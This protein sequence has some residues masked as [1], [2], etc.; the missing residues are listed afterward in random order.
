MFLACPIGLGNRLPCSVCGGGIPA[1]NRTHR[2]RI[3][4]ER[5]DELWGTDASRFWTKLESWCWFFAAVDHCASDVVGWHV[6]KKGDRWAAL[7]ML[8]PTVTNR[9]LPDCICTVIT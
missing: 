6:A 1:E 5:P 7:A 4:T 2:G 8:S 9:C 3:R